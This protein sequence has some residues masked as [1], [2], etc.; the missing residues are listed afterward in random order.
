MYIYTYN[1]L[2]IINHSIIRYRVWI[3]IKLARE[4]NNYGWM[5]TGE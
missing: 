2:T 5:N 3:L 1:F 4:A